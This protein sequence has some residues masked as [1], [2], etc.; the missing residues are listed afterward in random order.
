M[1]RY[2]GSPFGTIIGKLGDVVGFQW[3]GINCIRKDFTPTNPNALGQRA[4]RLIY[5]ILQKLGARHYEELLVPVW[6]ALAK[7]SKLPISGIN[8]LLKKSSRLLFKSTLNGI[9][10]PDYTRMCVS[11]GILEPTSQV[12][13]TAYDE[14]TGILTIDWDKEIYR[15]GKP[16]DNA[17]LLLYRTLYTGYP[18]GN[19]YVLGANA[20]RSAGGAVVWTQPGLPAIDLTTFVFFYDGYNYSP[21]MSRS[22]M[23]ARD[24]IYQEKEALTGDWAGAYTKIEE[25]KILRTSPM[26]AYRL[27]T[28]IKYCKLFFRLKSGIEGDLDSNIVEQT[29]AIETRAVAQLMC[30]GQEEYISVELWGQ[31]SGVGTPRAEN[32]LFY[33][34]IL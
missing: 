19:S 13:D 18:G 24:S 15:N 31:T 30:S 32:L 4:V 29:G 12:V 11:D 26:R 23:Q 27:Y 14:A 3:K 17:V 28:L 22:V 20:T 34:Y 21:S 5:I 7:R 16:T 8:L 33:G 2:T 10:A 9:Q 1:A 6:N 25:F